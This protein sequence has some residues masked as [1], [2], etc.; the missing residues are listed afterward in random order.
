MHN[1]YLLPD[2]QYLHSKPAYFHILA[3]F[4]GV[5]CEMSYQ[6]LGKLYLLISARLSTHTPPHTSPER[7]LTDFQTRVDH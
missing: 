4:H 2:G 5:F 6:N 7:I 3:A 1:V